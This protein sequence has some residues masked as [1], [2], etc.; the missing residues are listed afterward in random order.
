M[1]L[2]AKPSIMHTTVVLTTVLAA[3]TCAK[4]SARP[5]YNLDKPQHVYLL[6][7]T[8]LRLCCLFVHFQHA[9]QASACRQ[10]LQH[11]LSVKFVPLTST[12]GVSGR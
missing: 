6:V 7:H 12:M 3:D 10:M 9:S 1:L 11:Q 8:I 2:P 4:F 5:H